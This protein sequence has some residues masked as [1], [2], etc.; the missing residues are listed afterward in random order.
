MLPQEQQP[1]PT[2]PILL[3][4][5]E[6]QWVR[7]LVFPQAKARARVLPQAR[8]PVLPQALQGLRGAPRPGIRP[9]R[10][11]LHGLRPWRRPRVCRLRPIRKLRQQ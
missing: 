4:V 3:P 6:Q 2:V 9:R 8:V 11:W 7:V 1:V 5:L 10:F